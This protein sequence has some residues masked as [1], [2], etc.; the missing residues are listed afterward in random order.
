MEKKLT[1]GRI[2]IISGPSGVG[3]GTVIH[4][5]TDK[6]SIP[7]SISATTRHPREGETD[8]INYY[9]LSQVEFEEKIRSH[10]FLEWAQVH[11]YYYGTL[12]SSVNSVLS[13]GRNIL[14]E[15][16]VQGAKLVMDSNYPVLS[17]FLLPPS[18]E[19]LKNRLEKR[20]TDS[21]ESIA[22]RV[23]QAEVEI[24]DQSQYNYVITNDNVD[25]TV[26]KIVNIIT[27]LS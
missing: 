3:K 26:Q 1:T 24:L 4:K 5:L 22:S 19:E 21:P 7:V 6:L 23:K 12:R 9:F 10:S 14:L 11:G 17:I 15:I 2:I 27:E 16:D 20:Q 8:G 25:K 18:L 13:T